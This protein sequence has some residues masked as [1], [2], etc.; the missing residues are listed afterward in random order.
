METG[1]GFDSID[2]NDEIAETAGAISGTWTVGPS[3]LGGLLPGVT[4]LSNGKILYVNDTVSKLYD[5]TT[6]A[7]SSAGTVPDS[8]FIP[9]VARLQDGR[10]LVVS[11]NP[12][13][14]TAPTDIYNPATNTWSRTAG[15]RMGHIAGAA[16]T[17]PNGKVLAAAGFDCC[18][19]FGAHNTA[20]VYDPASVYGWTTTSNMLG[21]RAYFG[22]VLLPNGKVLAASGDTAELYEPTT[23]KWTAT[24]KMNGLYYKSTLTLLQNGKVLLTGDGNV[25]TELYDP[26]TGTWSYTGSMNVRHDQVTVVK[27]ASGK[28]LI[29]SGTDGN[30]RSELY[31][32][33]TGTWSFTY[34]M[35]ASGWGF[36]LA[37]LPNGGAAAFGAFANGNP[38]QLFT[39]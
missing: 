39:P 10:V 8:H 11:Q 1:D 2:E 37:P 38:V 24:G 28:V 30:K 12:Y 23:N 27:L 26:A 36:S 21:A 9:T 5:P 31:D 29:G 15:A 7:V 14:T 33:A 20:E 22:M 25:A 3:G 35:I 17:L 19:G 32:P 4:P 6:G 13:G 16:V 34:D 18:Y